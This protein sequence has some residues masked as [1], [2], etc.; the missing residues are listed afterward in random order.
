MRIDEV[1]EHGLEVLKRSAIM[2]DDLQ[3]WRLAIRTI[4]IGSGNEKITPLILALAN[5][6]YSHTLQDNLMQLRIK[7]RGN[8]DLK[9]SFKTGETTTNYWTIR[10]GC[11][12]NIDG[13]GFTG[14]TLYIQCDKPNMT[15]EVMELYS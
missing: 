6:E 14:K 11:V 15:V 2:P 3:K 9:I 10:K 13:L 1:N 8:A 4:L 12:D 7:C 5:T